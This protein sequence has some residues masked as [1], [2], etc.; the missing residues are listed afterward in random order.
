MFRSD[1]KRVSATICRPIGIDFPDSIST[2]ASAIFP[3]GR[4]KLKISICEESFA[5]K[6]PSHQ[7]V[8][9]PSFNGNKL[10]GRWIERYFRDPM[11]KS[12]FRQVPIPRPVS[13]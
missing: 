1:W 2:A 3:R 6:R 11:P 10:W 8:F 7:S 5:R 9:G 4:R 13:R 12:D